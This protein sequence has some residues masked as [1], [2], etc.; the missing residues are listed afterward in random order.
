MTTRVVTDASFEVD[1]LRADRPV[2]VDF[3]APW[4][5]PCRQVSPVMDELAA[6]YDTRVHVVKVNTDENP[7]Y[8][9]KYGVTGLPTVAVYDRGEQVFTITGSQPKHVLLRELLPWLG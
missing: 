6:V 2:I 7:L 1:V 8:A 3:W 5:G 4:C 9:G